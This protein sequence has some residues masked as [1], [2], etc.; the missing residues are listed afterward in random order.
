MLQSSQF[1]MSNKINIGVHRPCTQNLFEDLN[2]FKKV[3]S[4]IT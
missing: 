4:P 3:Y 2:N 1:F